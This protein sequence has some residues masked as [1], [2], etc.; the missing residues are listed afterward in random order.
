M[1][2]HPGCQF[3]F[4][5]TL[6][7]LLASLARCARAK[8]ERIERGGW[9]PP[10]M[11]GRGVRRAATWTWTPRTVGGAG[12]R[13]E[14]STRVS[15]ETR[16]FG[17]ATFSA[18]PD[19]ARAASGTAERAASQKIASGIAMVQIL[20]HAG[21]AAA[22]TCSSSSAAWRRT[23]SGSCRRSKRHV[24]M[25]GRPG[26]QVLLFK[27]GF[28]TVRARDEMTPRFKDMHVAY[29]WTSRFDGR[30]CLRITRGFFLSGLVASG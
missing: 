7:R 14:P 10:T 22:L 17:T 27:R 12:R 8:T 23:P 26:H 29:L 21:R 19:G 1:H 15:S 24:R 5:S 25:P 3:F 16:S 18:E 11:R 4:F 2:A 6:H 28:E 13:G 20:S 9:A 30:S